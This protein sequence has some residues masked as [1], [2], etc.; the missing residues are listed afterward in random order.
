MFNHEDVIGNEI[1]QVFFVCFLKNK[2]KF[3]NNPFADEN[4]NKKKNR[5]N[6]FDFLK[7]K[8]TQT[9]TR[10]ATFSNREKKG[11]KNENRREI[12]HFKQQ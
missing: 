10:I 11:K 6:S 12:H 8:Q 9:H 2:K 4:G 5:T 1:N 3:P 7:L